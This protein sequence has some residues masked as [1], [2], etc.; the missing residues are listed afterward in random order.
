MIALARTFRVL[1][2]AALCASLSACISLLPKSDPS[3]LYRFD[4]ELRAETEAPAPR[5]AT[6]FAVVRS[7]GGFVQAASNDQIMTINGDQVA[8]IAKAR[9]VSPASTLFNEAMTM[10]FNKNEGAARLL[11]R[12]EVG[13]ADYALR[14]DV[15]RFEA[16]YD[17]GADA[18]PNIMVALRVTLVAA[19][20]TLAGSDLLEANVRASDN[21]ISAIVAA[22]DT[23]VGQVLNQL[24]TWTNQT[25]SAPA[26][27]AAR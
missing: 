14:V 23:A 17:R 4:G 1:S 12:G 11:S 5:P 2:L 15:T 3:Q 16:I 7:G 6:R 20:R 26:A 10:A 24:V 9:W 19:D 18:A 22:F 21:R 27:A 13:K 8:Y 25:G